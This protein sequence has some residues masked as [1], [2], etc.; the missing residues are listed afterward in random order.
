V[1]KLADAIPG[2]EL[3]VAI[4]IGFGDE[5]N[6]GAAAI[7]AGRRLK[8]CSEIIA[9]CPF[10]EKVIAGKEHSF[11]LLL[12]MAYGHVVLMVWHRGKKS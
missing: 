5:L 2:I 3:G 10:F 12:P 9:A 4:G 11:P 6:D 1:T 8:E 7:S